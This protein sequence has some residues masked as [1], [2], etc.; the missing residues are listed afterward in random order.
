MYVCKYCKT[1]SMEYKGQCEHCNKWNCLIETDPSEI[2]PTDAEAERDPTKATPITEIKGNIDKRFSTGI[3][4]VD[5]VLGTSGGISGIVYPS[6]VLLAGEPGIGKST[7]LLQTGANVARDVGPVVYATGEES[8][9][10]LAS[11]AARLGVTHERLLVMATNHLEHVDAEVKR[12]RPRLLIVDS[13]QT[14]ARM[15]LS[16]E[17]GS[18]TQVRGLPGHLGPLARIKGQEMAVVIVGHVNKEGQA[19]GPKTLEHLVDVVLYFEGDK[20]RTLRT[21]RSPSKNRFNNTQ[22]MGVLEMT[23]NGLADVV[24]PSKHFLA[25][26]RPDEPGAVVTSVCQGTNSRRAILVEVQALLGTTELPKLV[27]NVSG[28]EQAR[29]VLMCAV[30]ARKA[31]ITV[32]NS[33]L[34]AQT[35]G[36]MDIDDRAADLALSIAIASAT[37]GR[38]MHDDMV[39]FG[40]VDLMGGLRDVPQAQVRLKEA[41]SNGFRRALVPTF[42]DLDPVDGIELVRAES[43]AQ[44]VELALV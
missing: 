29:V 21:I 1:P 3:A 27:V 23:Q 34:Y 19:A 25:Q 7:V 24:N 33:A 40:E 2:I 14:M 32:E 42:R 13:T 8:Q 17:P 11:R 44:A 28:L 18:I 30:L 22:D 41:A 6:L 5:R 16:G 43:L 20:E 26:R 15:D 39:V 36:G 9:E 38:P 4:E 31:N 12:W 37:T 35:I 10:A